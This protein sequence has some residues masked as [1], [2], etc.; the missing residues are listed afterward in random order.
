MVGLMLLATVTTVVA[1]PAAC[2]PMVAFGRS[3]SELRC[4]D[5]TK[6]AQ[7]SQL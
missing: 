1:L 5:H 6:G 2:P 4:E 7:R 3:D